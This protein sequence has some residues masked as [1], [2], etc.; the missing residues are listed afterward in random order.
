MVSVDRSGP[1]FFEVYVIQGYRTALSG[2][3]AILCCG[4]FQVLHRD[5]CELPEEKAV[6]RDIGTRN[7]GQRGTLPL[8]RETLLLCA[9]S[10]TDTRSHR[11][12]TRSKFKDVAGSCPVI[13]NLSG[14]GC[15]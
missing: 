4:N 11:I 7:C 8:N 6:G 1:A 2:V 13:C 12:D 10:N 5:V 3:E 9:S 15:C 14:E